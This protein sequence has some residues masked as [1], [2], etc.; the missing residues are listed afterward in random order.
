M[1]PVPDT[2]RIQGGDLRAY[3]AGQITVD[4]SIC[5]NPYGPSPRAI[6]AGMRLLAES[7]GALAPPPYGCE[8][9]YLDAYADRLGVPATELA[10]G[11]GV[12]EF[13]IVLARL[14]RG[15][16]P[17]VITPD[18]THTL[19]LFSYGA[20]YVPGQAVL[21]TDIGRL[22]RLRRAMASQSVVVLS[23]PCNPTGQCLPPGEIISICTDFP[24]SLM[25][26]DEEYVDLHGPGLTTVG[27]DVDNLVV[28]RSTGKSYGIVG[29]RA[30]VMWT[31]SK[32][33]LSLV[34]MEMQ[35][36][37]RLS[38]LDAVMAAA[39]LQDEQWL[40]GTRNALHRDAARL[41]DH[42]R[43]AFGPRARLQGPDHPLH[44]RFVHL[45]NPRP[46]VEHLSEHG[47]SVRSF[48]DYGGHI[49][50]IRFAAPSTDEQLA[51]LV[52]AL[53]TLPEKRAA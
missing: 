36:P 25:I 26:L 39:A 18:Y 8:E 51:T 50:G 13:L 7:P 22:T 4:L 21:D 45:P 15:R 11:R 28:L 35:D 31:R 44:Y 46:V 37:W 34:R 43:D 24:Q 14:L 1:H 3:A 52:H 12:T 19:R 10:A 2:V 16:R 32:E 5:H 20:Q 29:T 30:G 23:N 40:E 17:A 38:L 48:G 41:E 49:P 33:L 42:L 6:E 53:N 27:A 47:V 9:P